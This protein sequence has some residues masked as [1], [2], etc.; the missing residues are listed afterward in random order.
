MK[1][2]VTG[3]PRIVTSQSALARGLGVDVATVRRALGDGRIKRTG[4]GYDV[5]ATRREWEANTNPRLSRAGRR[6]RHAKDAAV[7]EVATPGDVQVKRRALDVIDRTLERHDMDPVGEA[8]TLFNAATANEI[9]KTY[10]L[11]LDIDRIRGKLVEAD[12]ARD[13]LATF[14]RIERDAILAWPTSVA[15]AFASELGYADFP[16]LETVLTRLVRELLATLAA[17]PS[18]SDLM[19]VAK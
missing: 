16:L 2:G 12:K 15:P 8:C 6:L 10:K 18:T 17:V 3:T 9:L 13:V 5:E 11:Q 19:P 4:A 7:A 1:Q 14:T